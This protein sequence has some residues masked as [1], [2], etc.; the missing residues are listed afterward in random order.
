MAYSVQ[1][2]YNPKVL[3]D[4]QGYG[5]GITAAGNAF[6]GALGTYAGWK[7]QDKTRAED[8][9]WSVE[10]REARFAQE[11]EMQGRRFGHDEAMF[12][13]ELGARKEE[14]EMRKA[15]EE[16]ALRRT[17]AGLA[18]A[19]QQMGIPAEE[20]APLAGMNPKTANVVLQSIYGRAGHKLEQAEKL[21]DF[22]TKQ[23]MEQ[24]RQDA[25]QQP[26]IIHDPLTGEPTDY[27]GWGRMALPRP[28]TKDTAA[29]RAI[30]FA[31]EN[32]LPL[33]SVTAGGMKF[34]PARAD[35]SKPQAIRLADGT[36]VSA[37]QDSK[38]GEWV[39]VKVKGLEAEPPITGSPLSEVLRRR[40]EAQQGR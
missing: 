21:Q 25:E 4:T 5:P 1:D 29:E 30:K 2:M 9:A 35:E 39:P 31:A 12:G 37:V 40:A 22:A 32:G 6:S 15:M 8:R 33:Q 19:A 17:N 26:R 18:F 7:R 38:T 34:G 3:P 28:G 23:A 16:E 13:K 27:I 14:R 10:D 24:A 11:E 36:I 20:L